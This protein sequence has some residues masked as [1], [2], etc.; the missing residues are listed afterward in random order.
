MQRQAP[1][2][3]EENRHAHNGEGV[4][5]GQTGAFM[6]G[7]CKCCVCLDKRGW[8]SET[9]V[10]DDYC[11][12]EMMVGD[13]QEVKGPPL[14]DSCIS[15]LFYIVCCSH[16]P[17]AYLINLAISLMFPIMTHALSSTA[18]LAATH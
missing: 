15:A 17:R 13:G 9:E 11:G 2:E 10:W 1:W 7:G 16:F 14:L 3:G 5:G 18:T 8:M 6:E 4:G 12:L